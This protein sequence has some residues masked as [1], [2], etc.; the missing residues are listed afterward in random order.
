MACVTH[1]AQD[2]RECLE[3]IHRRA[4]AA[5]QSPI[6]IAIFFESLFSVLEQSKDGLR[7]ICLFQHGSKGFLREVFS[8]YFGVF[9]QGLDD[10]LG[11]RS[12]GC[13]LSSRCHEEI[14]L[15]TVFRSEGTDCGKGKQARIDGIS[16]EGSTMQTAEGCEDPKE[17]GY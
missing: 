1:L 2:S 14:K 3:D 4:K 11:V 9:I 5:F 17:A 16:R 13:C 15:L 7:R 12:R 6:A 10:Q 8:S